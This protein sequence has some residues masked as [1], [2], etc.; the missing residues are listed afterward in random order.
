MIQG[1]IGSLSK[2]EFAQPVMV[3]TDRASPM[4]I[5]AESITKT[6]IEPLEAKVM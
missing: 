2:V 6:H 4:A 5:R 3:L 1:Q